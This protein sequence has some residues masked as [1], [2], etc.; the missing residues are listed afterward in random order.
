MLDWIPMDFAV[1]ANKLNTYKFAAL[2]PQLSI[3]T[4]G[5]KKQ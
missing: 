2:P 3:L 4:G 5:I 1:F